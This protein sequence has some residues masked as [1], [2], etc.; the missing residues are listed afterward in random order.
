M[1]FATDWNMSPYP[2]S[3][4]LQSNEY[5]H[6]FLND[7]RPH[8]G[9]PYLHYTFLPCRSQNP[10]DQSSFHPKSPRKSHLIFG[11]QPKIWNVCWAKIFSN[12]M[13]WTWMEG[14]PLDGGCFACR[15]SL[16]KTRP[17]TGLAEQRPWSRAWTARLE[18][19]QRLG[20]GWRSGRPPP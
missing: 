2:S 11:S 8:S 10:E 5:R 12:G 20:T 1:G 7:L 4:V 19:A 9:H 6:L 18:V 15:E 3:A 17:W 13:F 16:G 14:S